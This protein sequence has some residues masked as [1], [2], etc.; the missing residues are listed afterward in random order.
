MRTLAVPT[1]TR[2]RQLYALACCESLPKPR[3]Q[4]GWDVYDLHGLDADRQDHDGR[5]IGSPFQLALRSAGHPDHSEDDDAARGWLTR[6]GACK[7]R[8]LVELMVV[9]GCLL[10]FDGK[11]WRWRRC[12]EILHGLAARADRHNKA[13]Q[14]W[15][16]V[17]TR[18]RVSFDAKARSSPETWTQL[19]TLDDASSTSQTAQLDPGFSRELAAVTHDFDVDD[20]YLGL[21][22]T[23]ERVPNP[24]GK[25]PSRWAMARAVCSLLLELA[26]AHPGQ[27]TRQDVDLEIGDGLLAK[28]GM[29][30]G[31]V[32]DHV[33]SFVQPVLDR[34]VSVLGRVTDGVASVLERPGLSVLHSVLRLRRSPAAARPGGRPPGANGHGAGRAGTAAASPKRGPP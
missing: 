21:A 29:D 15:L 7:E 30:L 33:P 32:Q 5:W 4:D 8:C 18:T 3:S 24:E 19:V 6:R 27:P 14:Q 10:W 26:P 34:L 31:R 13:S 22:P 16:G 2:A 1:G 25:K 23:E 11:V 17:F 28:Y 12:A 20:L 9:L